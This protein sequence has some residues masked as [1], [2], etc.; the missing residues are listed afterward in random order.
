METLGKFTLDFNENYT[1]LIQLSKLL[2]H[3][4]QL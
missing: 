1:D 4:N 3:F 2:G